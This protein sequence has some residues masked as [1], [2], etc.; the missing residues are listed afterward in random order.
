MIQETEIIFD[1]RAAAAAAAAE[2]LGAALSRRLEGQGKASLVVSGG[3]SPAGVFRELAETELAWP[4]VHVILSDERWVPPDHE[5]SNERLV[6]ETLLQGAAQDAT[7]LP[8]SLTT[9]H[10]P[11][12]EIAQVAFRAMQERIR[13]PTI[14]PRTLT[15][16]PRWEFCSSSPIFR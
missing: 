10:Q 6:R 16:A 7:L 1:S 13:E 14:P 15:L 4:D 8:V 5:D 11:C 12:R 9:I 2:R 3:T